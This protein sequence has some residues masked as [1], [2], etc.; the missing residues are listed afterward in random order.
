MKNVTINGF[1]TGIDAANSDFILSRGNIRR[2]GIG[3]NLQNSHATFHDTYLMDNNV[4]LVVNNSNVH[5]ID[6]I[7]KRIIAITPKGDIRVNPY[8][9]NY[10]ANQIINTRD[11]RKKKRWLRQLWNIIKYTSLVWTVY[12]IFE[13]ILRYL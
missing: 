1:K 5:I 7:A 9:I 4:D 11:V 10:I 8:Q 6:T 13:R 3:V 12:Q 2:C